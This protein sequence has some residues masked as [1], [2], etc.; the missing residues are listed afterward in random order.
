MRVEVGVDMVCWK[1]QMRT[2]GYKR[3][4]ELIS[5]KPH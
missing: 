4:G 5:R 2:D 3:M 1:N